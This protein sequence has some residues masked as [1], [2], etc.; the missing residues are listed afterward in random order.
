MVSIV[1]TGPM[2][3]EEEHAVSTI[4]PL[5][6]PL[7]AAMQDSP[8]EVPIGGALT[9]TAPEMSVKE[10]FEKDPTKKVWL[11]EVVNNLENNLTKTI[12]TGGSPEMAT[13]VGH[14]LTSIAHTGPSDL[15]P[16]AP[17]TRK[18]LQ[19]MVKYL[20]NP[21]PSVESCFSANE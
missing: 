20:R 8:E 4:K 19:S 16:C 7:E 17:S 10:H 9:E 21:L 12:E 5:T 2:V 11:E 13:P 15:T 14:F 3:R 18:I 1:E 6:Q